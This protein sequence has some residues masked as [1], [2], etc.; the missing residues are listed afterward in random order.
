MIF[1]SFSRLFKNYYLNC[2]FYRTIFDILEDFVSTMTLTIHFPLRFTVFHLKK[3]ILNFPKYHLQKPQPHSND[4]T[5]TH[6]VA[7]TQ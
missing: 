4:I 6:L 1:D 5:K 2:P 7:V 3:E